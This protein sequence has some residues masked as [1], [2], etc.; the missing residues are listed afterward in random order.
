LAAGFIS[1]VGRPAAV[2][3]LV[4]RAG[5]SVVDFFNLQP[6]AGSISGTIW[7]DING[8]GIFGAGES[9]LAGW[10]VY[11]DLNADGIL[12]AGEP[13]A[14]TPAAGTYSF[15]NQ[16]YGTKSV[17]VIPQANWAVTSPAAGAASFL[18]LNG[19]AR[20]A[21]N[22]GLRELLGDVRGVVVDDVNGNG[23]QETG[24]LPLPG[25][26]VFADLN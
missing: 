1:S 5:L 7:N 16:S 12:T 24:E 4:V 20:T 18:L 9:P 21:V 13:S 2:E 22:F 14:V 15:P 25:L 23:I 3:S 11:V 6:L 19:Q 26:T 17:R 8:D 10:T